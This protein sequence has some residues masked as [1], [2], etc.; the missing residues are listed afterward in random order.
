M[1]LRILNE[2]SA[3]VMEATRNIY[4]YKALIVSDEGY[5]YATMTSPYQGFRY[6]PN[7]LCTSG[8]HYPELKRGRVKK[9][10]HTFVD[11]DEAISYVNEGNAEWPERNA[12]CYLFVAV[13]PKGFRYVRGVHDYGRAS[14]A[15]EG[16]I[17]L[18][19]THRESLKR[20]ANGPSLARVRR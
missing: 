13:I 16:L 7:E 9:G 2:K 17:V 15:S 11:R 18:P 20:I 10:F 4:A 5:V 6:Y 8:F 3:V 1:C 19:R 14:Y 12:H